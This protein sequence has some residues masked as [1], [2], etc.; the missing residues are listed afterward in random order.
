MKLAAFVIPT[1]K[2]KDKV[3]ALIQSFSHIESLNIDIIIINGNP[4]DDTSRWLD[5]C[6]DNRI[7]ELAGKSDLYWSGLVNVG[8]RYILNDQVKPEYVFIMNADITFSSDILNEFIYIYGRVQPCQLA[9][10]TVANQ[11]I[12]SSGVKVRSWFFT[13]NRHP[14]AGYS[15]SALP[16]EQ[17]IPVDFLPTRCLMIPFVALVDAGLTA[18]KE[19]P[20]YGGDYEYTA[21]LSRLGYKAYI[22]TDIHIELDMLNTGADVYTKKLNIRQRASSVFSIKSQ[23]NP[24]S[25][26]KFVWLVYPWFARPSAII[27]YLF[28]S[29]FEIVLG[30]NTLKKIFQNSESGFSGR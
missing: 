1:F 19:L 18:E 17:L 13:I 22:T 30:G 23:S 4:N 20:H 21:R 8:L 6:D 24:I 27:L 14:F 11:K 28:R 25:K 29:I 12:L 15:I 3:E 2:E 9:A 7:I 16:K 26:I 5:S 10:V